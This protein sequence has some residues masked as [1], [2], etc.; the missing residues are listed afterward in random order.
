MLCFCSPKILL[1]SVNLCHICSVLLSDMGNVCK[2]RAL[3]FL[4]VKLADSSL[5]GRMPSCL[6]G[7]D[8]RIRRQSLPQG[9]LTGTTSC[10]T[11]KRKL[12]SIRTGKTTC[13]TQ[14]KRKVSPRG[15]GSTWQHSISLSIGE[16]WAEYLSTIPLVALKMWYCWLKNLLGYVFTF[17]STWP[18]S[19]F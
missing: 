6:Q 10:P 5:F 11:W 14:V 17:Q 8:R 16:W 18:V 12:W 9:H 2:H 13:P 19:T 15:E 1:L 3:A 7:F 4:A